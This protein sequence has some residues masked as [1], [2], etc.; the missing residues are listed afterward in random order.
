V[1]LPI[2]EYT[3]AQNI[4]VRDGT[5]Y[6]GAQHQGVL[7]SEDRG[8]TW[9]K[10]NEGLNNLC[11]C[12]LT[13][14]GDKLYAGV[15][16]GRIFCFDDE[17]KTWS[18]VGSGLPERNGGIGYNDVRLLTTSGKTLYAGI[19]GYVFCSEDGGNTWNQV[20][21]TLM[22]HGD[23]DMAYMPVREL[24]LFDGSLYV[25]SGNAIYR[26][27]AG[28]TVWTR[29]AGARDLPVGHIMAHKKSLYL[30]LGAENCVFRSEDGGDT[31]TQ[32]SEELLH[33]P[34][35]S[36]AASEDTIYIGTC[37]GVFRATLPE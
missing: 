7:R 28:G 36:L 26:L 9:T 24:L 25:G 32:I 12:S 35:L 5:L 20:G 21:P 27:N 22:D 33:P 15:L 8:R 29:L 6:I 16:K 19:V 13:L 30:Y 18:Q 3:P 14:L 11:V 23:E 34:A 37:G 31:W 1:E 10:I 2:L 17:T 4:V